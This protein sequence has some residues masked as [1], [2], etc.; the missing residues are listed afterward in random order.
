MYSRDAYSRS[1]SDSSR[2]TA[3]QHLMTTLASFSLA[4]IA[5]TGYGAASSAQASVGNSAVAAT[6]NTTT[7]AGVLALRPAESKDGPAS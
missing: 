4:V 3:R 2:H 7:Q 5:A 6:I 1:F